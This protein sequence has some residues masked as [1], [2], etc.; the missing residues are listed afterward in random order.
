MSGDATQLPAPV[1]S[2]NPETKPFW[3]ATAEGRFLLKR[4]TACRSVIWYPR[5]M[6]PECGSLETEW[7]E[8]SGR[9]SVY[10]FTVNYKGDGPYRAAPYVLA[11]VEL[12][13]G[14]RMMTN[15]VGTDP[16]QVSI[17]QSVKVVF[18]PT[19]EGPALPRFQPA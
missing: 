6:C 9:G 1:P 13:E 18:E 16:T 2:V 7:F 4:C 19:G 3:D 15:I 14:P 17:G 11:Y 8:A 12:E 5:A 10:S